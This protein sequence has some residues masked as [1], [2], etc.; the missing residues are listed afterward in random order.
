[1]LQIV[2]KFC[3][4]TKNSLNFRPRPFWIVSSSELKFENFVLGKGGNDIE[5]ETTGVSAERSQLSGAGNNSNS[6][7]NLNSSDGVGVAKEKEK[8]NLENKFNQAS[9]GEGDSKVDTSAGDEPVEQ[10]VD[11]V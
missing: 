6:N 4:F 5:C 10:P 1:M 11:A 3:V 8:E 2:L 9:E 7:S